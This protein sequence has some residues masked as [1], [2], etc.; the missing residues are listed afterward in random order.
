[1]A[2]GWR[3]E[4]M[5]HSLARRGIKTSKKGYKTGVKGLGEG[6]RRGAKAD[7]EVMED[8]A[9]VDKEV[10]KIERMKVKKKDVE[11]LFG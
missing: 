8:V 9:Q 11:N 6:L 10:E 7:K 5:R 1:M 4:P 2:K 3:R